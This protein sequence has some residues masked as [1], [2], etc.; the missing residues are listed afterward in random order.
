MIIRR[1]KILLFTSLLILSFI[2]YLF[3]WSKSP[4]MLGWRLLS[5]DYYTIFSVFD[6]LYNILNVIL[7][8]LFGFAIYVNRKHV[9]WI[10]LIIIIVSYVLLDKI[11]FSAFR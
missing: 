4:S 7:L 5:L 11:N 1:N 3:V 8:L 2:V 6:T 9:I 10:T